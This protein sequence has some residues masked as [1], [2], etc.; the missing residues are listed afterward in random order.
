MNDNVEFAL[1]LGGLGLLA[2]FILNKKPDTGVNAQDLKTFGGKQAGPP[3]IYPAGTPME[4]VMA[5]PFKATQ[6]DNTVATYDAMGNFTGY[7]NAPASS[8]ASG[9]W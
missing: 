7:E 8:G 4:P 1:M 2:Y 5:N 3:P 9:R 6:S